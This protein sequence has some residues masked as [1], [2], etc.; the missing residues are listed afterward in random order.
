MKK[1]LKVK[2]IAIL[3]T[4]TLTFIIGIII[5]QLIAEYKMGEFSSFATKLRTSLLTINTQEKIA[6]EYLCDVNIFK[7]TEEKSNLGRTLTYLED[8]F[9]KDNERII[10][11]KKEY[12]LISIRQ[13]LLVKKFSKE[14]N[15]NLTIILFFYSNINNK[16]ESEMQGFILDSLYLKYPKNVVIY[17]LDYDL[18]CKA[19]D[20]LENVYNITQVPSLVINDKT[21]LGF[22]PKNEIENIILQNV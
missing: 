7:L 2:Y 16:T 11:L 4:T 15:K 1:N 10:E 3:S 21:Y 8:K 19:I 17:A 18:D 14:C 22:V 9:G 20:T 12:S 6:S 5:G 13:F